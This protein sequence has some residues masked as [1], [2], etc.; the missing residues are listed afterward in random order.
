VP[1]TS[2]RPH[3]ANSVIAPRKPPASTRTAVRHVRWP[4]RVECC[5]A[6]AA[7]GVH[8]VQVSHPPMSRAA[9][10]RSRHA[11]VSPRNLKRR[12]MSATQR[13]RE[14]A[15]PGRSVPRGAPHSPLALWSP[16]LS[17]ESS[18]MARRAGSVLVSGAKAECRSW[19]RL[20][21]RMRRPRSC[22]QPGHGDPDPDAE[23]L[24][25][26]GFHLGPQ[27]ALAASSAGSKSLR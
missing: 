12:R 21:R 6:Q 10:I 8:P 15:V 7:L 9:P 3:S 1:A 23:R 27:D 19:Y 24:A 26:A 4:R 17:P 18:P 2:S 5:R 13:T 22:R 16:L 11:P 20:A 25:L 14:H